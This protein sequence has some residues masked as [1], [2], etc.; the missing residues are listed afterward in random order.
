MQAGM[1]VCMCA[2]MSQAGA[3]VDA[4]ATDL[5]PELQKHTEQLANVFALI[6]K[7]HEHLEAVKRSVDLMESRCA[8]SLSLSLYCVFVCVRLCVCIYRYRCVCMYVCTY[9]CIYVCI[10]VRM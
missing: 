2:C 1:H 6:D 9:V 3:E 8:R 5:V 4:I 10:Y 7:M